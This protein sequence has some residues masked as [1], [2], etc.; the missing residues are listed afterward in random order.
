VTALQKGAILAA[1]DAGLILAVAW[2]ATRDVPGWPRG[3]AEAV[4]S[5]GTVPGSRYVNL[6]L[7]VPA[8]DFPQDRLNGPCRLQVQ[9]EQVVCVFDPQ[10]A[11][12]IPHG[13][14]STRTLSRQY[15]LRL[16]ESDSAK[17]AGTRV[18][19]ELAVSA[20]G[21]LRVLRIIPVQQ[22]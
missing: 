2:T 20:D 19:A 18:L 22:P 6:E 8:R 17:P 15:R 10:G 5:R 4:V 16:A 14:G 12:W 13:Q 7:Q 9:H 11:E 1:V 21:R 3:W